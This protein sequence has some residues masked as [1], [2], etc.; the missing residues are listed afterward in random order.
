MN[1]F[2]DLDLKFLVDAVSIK[3]QNEFIC[4]VNVKNSI[5]IQYYTKKLEDRENKTRDISNISTGGPLSNYELTLTSENIDYA[6]DLIRQ[7]YILKR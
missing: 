1:E 2:D 6:I 5:K 4:I 7:V 3:A